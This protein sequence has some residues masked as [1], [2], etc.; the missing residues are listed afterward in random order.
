MTIYL[1]VAVQRIGEYLTRVPKLKQLRGASAAISAATRLDGS[2]WDDLRDTAVRPNPETGEADGVLHLVVADG[3]DPDR[4]ARAVLSVLRA[5]LPGAQLTA[6]WAAASDYPSAFRAMH[7]GAAE[8]VTWLPATNEFPVAR[9]CGNRGGDD[10]GCGQRPGGSD[11]VADLCPDC[12]RRAGS[13][14]GASGGRAETL[15]AELGR[16]VREIARLCPRD[17]RPPRSNHVATVAIDGNGVGGYFARLIEEGDAEK[18][19]SVSRALK[20][21]TERAFAEAAHHV[22][23]GGQVGVI[24]VVLGGD[25]VVAIVAAV[26]AWDFV[27]SFQQAFDAQLVARLGAGT[28]ISASAGL[29]FHHA[30]APITTNVALADDLMRRAKARHSGADAAVCWVDTTV[31]ALDEEGALSRRAAVRIADLVR[32]DEAIAALSRLPQSARS[33]LRRETDELDSVP[34]SDDDRRDYIVYRADRIKA[35]E[36]VEAFPFPDPEPGRI[37]LRVALDL[38]EWWP[39]SRQGVRA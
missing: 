13:G 15:L 2:P 35:R 31:D 9:P 10:Q 32:S 20:D 21:A 3:Q 36:A 14:S 19:R 4:A 34:I 8:P 16:P 29:V 39:A 11:G 6:T 38:A 33:N 7:A 26:D 28:G 12:R 25:D 27:L 1:D 18:R 24:P 23:R 5:A 37:E 17:E 22:S 30:K